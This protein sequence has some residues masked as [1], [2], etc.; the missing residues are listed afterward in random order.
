MR[1]E[2]ISRPVLSV[3]FKTFFI[4]PPKPEEVWSVLPPKVGDNT[5]AKVD[6]KTNN[7]KEGEKP[8]VLGLDGKWLRREGVIMIYRDITNKENLFW[9]YW[10][11]ESYQ[12]LKTDLERL[13]EL[14]RGSGKGGLKEDFPLGTVSDWKGAIVAGVSTLLPSLPHQRCLTHVV[15]EAKRL[16]PM[17]SPF[18]STRRLRVIAKKLIH[19]QSEEERRKW[20]SSLLRWER[21]Y[22]YRLRER[23]PGVNT[24]KKWWYTHGNLRRGW[25]LLTQNWKPFF[26]HLS[27]PLIPRS[28]N[29][30]EGVNSQLKKRLT[31]HR[32]MRISQQVSFV[33]WYLAFS[34]VKNRSDLKKLW[35]AWKQQ[36]S[37]F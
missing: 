24:K 15:R 16:L 5:R 9:S 37:I 35:D 14:L 30:L 27:H 11:S 1:E 19:I 4:R 10:S 8:W 21:R 33:F 13:T 23:T 32:G 36:K 7:A 25:R 28:N 29:S 22:G 31:S 17:R 6:G 3:K 26:V 34:R 2:K 12:A 20:I 18:L